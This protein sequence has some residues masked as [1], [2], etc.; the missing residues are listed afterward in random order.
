[1]ST[2][3]RLYPNTL[4]SLFSK[5]HR[6]YLIFL[7]ALFFMLLS[8]I[9]PA[10]SQV[11]TINPAKIE[12]RETISVFF[13][14]PQTFT[15]D[16]LQ[17][18]FTVKVFDDTDYEYV[19][20]T[21]GAWHLSK[22]GY[23]LSYYPVTQ[24]S[25]EVHT[26]QF[27]HLKD[28]SQKSA[29]IYIGQVSE[30]VKILG[31]GPVLPIKNA[32]LP[33][34]LIG[35]EAVDIE[36][37]AIDNLPHLLENYYIGTSLDS[38]S[39]SRLVKE[40][41]P[42]G[43][44]RYV[45][46]SNTKVDERSKHRIPLDQNIKPGAYLVTVNP[47]GEIYKTIDTRIV[48]ISNIGLQARL[49]PESTLI[50]ANQFTD[51]APLNEATLEVWRD[52]NGKL[53]KSE[54]L[55]TFENGLCQLPERL[56]TTDVVVV[57]AGDDLSIL[58]MKEIALDLNEFAVTGAPSTKDVAYLYS[59][60]TLYRPGEVM[61]INALLRNFNGEL[62]PKQPLNLALI[63]PQGKVYSNFQL[64]QRQDGFYQTEIKMPQ[65]AKTGV[66]HLEA[67]TDATS[68]KAL[69]RLKLYIEE[70][71]PERMELI[72]TGEDRPLS[73]DEPFTLTINS[74]Y[75]FGATASQNA[76]NIQNELSINRT[77]F[78]GNQD[79]YAGIEDFPFGK[80]ASSYQ[81]EGSLNDNGEETI[82]LSVP[83]PEDGSQVSAVLKLDSAV[84]ILDGSVL[85]ITREI[86]RN[87]WPNETIPVIR[88]LFK[89][90]EIGYGADAQFELFSANNAGDIVPSDFLIT[91]KYLD[92]SCTWIFS[93]A[94]GWDCH[95]SYD[96]QIR[97][98]KTVQ[99]SGIIDYEFS[100]NSWGRYLLEVKDLTSGL[101]SE[102]AF[103]GSWEESG[104]GQLPAVKP[105]HL[106]LSTQKPNFVP[107][108]TIELTIN[109][110]LAGNLT[111][112]VEGDEV[113]Y[114]ENLN[115]DKGDTTLTIEMKEDWNRHDLYL[116]GVLISN[117]AQDETVR[118]L[119]IIPLKI[120]T[121][122]RK[123][124]PE[125]Q[126]PA[127]AKPD[128]PI[129]IEVSLSKSD[130][131][132]LQDAGDLDHLYATISITDQGILNMIPEKPVSIFDAFFKQR[133]Y[134]AEI[135]D[136][137]SRLFKRGEGSLL[138]PQFGGDG[139]FAE[140]KE[141][142]IPNLT[143]M[144]TVSLTSNLISLEDGKAEITFDLPDFNGEALVNVK[145]FNKTQ[146]GEASESLA[147][148]APIVADIVPPRF[149]RVGDQS[150]MALTLVNMSGIEDTAKI[151][152]TSEAFTDQAGNHTLFEE[153][154]TLPIEGK[155]YKLIPLQLDTFT[156]FAQ[157]TL[158]IE[159]KSFNAK[160]DYQIG[161]VHKTIE[162]ALYDK[163]LLDAN[164]PFTRDLA[165]T[166]H[167][168]QGFKEFLT[169]SRNPQINVLSYTSGLFEYPYG[170]TEQTTSKAFPW[171]F[172]SNPILDQEKQSA[173]QR[174]IDR[175]S[176][177]E[178]I[179]FNDWETSMMKES[180]Q[181]LLDRQN[182]DGGFALWS[183]GPSFLPAS[184]YVTDFLIDA[185]R[186]F[187]ALVPQSALE[188]A[189]SYLKKEL[190]R[191]QEAY[192]RYGLDIDRD[193]QGLLTRS[194]LA[195]VSYASWILAK[196]GKIFSADILFMHNLLERLT[197]LASSYMG[198]SGLVL[199]SSAL[200]NDFI[201]PIAG[202]V[203]ENDQRYGYY[204]SSVSEIAGILNVLNEL[205]AK[206]YPI[207][208]ELKMD[209]MRVLDRELSHRQYF[210]TQDRYALIKLGIDMPEDP[211]PIEVIIN[212]Q[213]Q[214]I[215]A[216][217]PMPANS[218]GTLTSAEPLFME[219][220]ISGF[221][222]A[223]VSVTNFNMDYQSTMNQLAGKQYKVG[224]RVEIR[225]EVTPSVNL[226]SALLASYI[227]G[228]FN[229][230]NPNLASEDIDTFYRDLGID[231]E[232]RNRMEHE[233][234]RFDRYVASL[235][236]KADEKQTFIYILEAS[237]PGE[238]EIP[239]TIL[240]DMYLPELHNMMVQPGT[241]TI[242]E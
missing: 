212:G 136:Y 59:N 210:S 88:P 65:D 152:I 170:C 145:L 103:N 129:T 240:E 180:I 238:Y 216:N 24:G 142:A 89:S 5:P 184:A 174:A 116:S 118:S 68:E 54:T 58:P 78:A 148:H 208:S 29:D 158:N 179:S 159:S 178:T 42:A 12:G 190:S 16:Q 23:R 63:N 99:A 197:P 61:T 56:K 90:E 19:E 92:P 9:V 200:G 151:T 107:G 37:Y 177:K 79:W 160:R 172:P 77:P 223:P 49:Y 149:I 225:I 192:N 46:P 229:L 15:K 214:S 230:V 137:Y 20:D 95:Y 108:E 133:Q 64:D 84:N 224:D 154:I 189:F 168:D 125:L 72:L 155:S 111:L 2:F 181:R 112:L 193:Y 187:P 135:I 183:E 188:N 131:E 36:Y 76:Y 82:M 51:N 153:S 17:S 83:M 11:S 134:S 185:Q 205:T 204:Q 226:P 121:A 222:K 235:P 73:I 85:G 209:L 139:V 33:V 71:M 166:T 75:L 14:S 163:R 213:T 140:E 104:S 164:K 141:T 167:Y 110:P 218:I 18:Q 132:K 234:F 52:K 206:G 67:R 22:D 86:S 233:E 173:Y 120:N 198:A 128:H 93:N 237:V 115:I 221:P 8:S 194:R 21:Q 215:S 43:I 239:V 130:L 150:Y 147:I 100:P 176:K 13:D 117:N 109:A 106:N 66:W 165:I 143:E 186:K 211:K 242:T 219:Y 55:C 94:R 207:S 6:F 32:S 40:T 41:T 47:A 122:E 162:T 217:M 138:N 98:Q 156:P 87:F 144:K 25:Y 119:G 157:V 10:F 45:V 123:L 97:E 114:K 69:G 3:P 38:W 48:F 146:M 203:M 102:F 124:T 201:E 26:D 28:T 81:S 96:Y 27:K 227:P 196:S 7:F 80:I 220:Q 127:V 228:G 57:K 35:T 105:L 53:E 50:I 62:L 199:G 236:M 241:I 113:L 202:K 91:L 171:L 4:I 31:R 231:F 101:V 161:T 44:F 30:G 39:V 169:L 1:M 191:T 182:I 195:S 232:Q 126:F 74:R 175:S 70:F 34:E 60:R